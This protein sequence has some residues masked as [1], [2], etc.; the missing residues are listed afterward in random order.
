MTSKEM[1]Q[2]MQTRKEVESWMQE[3]NFNVEYS[4]IEPAKGTVIINHGTNL[5]LNTGKV[6]LKKMEQYTYEKLKETCLEYLRE[7]K[8]ES[9]LKEEIRNDKITG[10]GI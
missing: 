9:L 2:L 8:I 4:F 7:Y 6:S 1:N 3:N 5:V 10:L